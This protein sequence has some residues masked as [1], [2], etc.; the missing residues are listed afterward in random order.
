MSDDDGDLDALVR[1]VDE[2]RWLASRFVSDAEARADVIALYALNYELSRAAEV[3]SQPLIGEMRL[4]W[5]RE[6]VEEICD[7]RPVRRHPV[8]LALAQAARRRGLQRAGLEALIDSRLRE[9][10]PWPLGED[11]VADY[12]DATAG[13]LMTLA[14]RI[15]APGAGTD[16]R[17]AARAWG[18]A[19]LQRLGGRLPPAWGA[20]ELLRR[21]SEAL[22]EANV[23]L[24]GL[25]VAAF[26]AVAYAAL[27]R[28]YAAGEAPT[29]LSRR[30]RLTWAVLRGRV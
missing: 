26:P 8:A 11:E 6:A 17:P 7:G 1:R 5:W 3:A 22:G 4:A 16:L 2:D 23:A 18:L 28:S 15:L 10:D 21:V 19:G 20:G 14:V 30:L 27:A 25:P 9:L 24:R 13:C 29:E 12:L